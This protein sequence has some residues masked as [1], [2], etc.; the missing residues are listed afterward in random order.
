MNYEIFLLFPV[1]MMKSHVKMMYERLT[2][3]AVLNVLACVHIC[4][5]A[6]VRVNGCEN[7]EALVTRKCKN[8]HYS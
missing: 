5:A 8:V 7:A 2:R 4:T 1:R 6:L 3:C